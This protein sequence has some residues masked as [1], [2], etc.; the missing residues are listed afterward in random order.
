MDSVRRR[1]TASLPALGVLALAA[2]HGLS[3]A[4]TPAATEAAAPPL[5]AVG[6]AL[7]LPE[8]RLFDGSVLVPSQAQGKITLIYWWASTCPFC[9]LQS[10]EMQKLW[11][12]H[13][14]RGLQMLALSVDRKPQEAEAYLQKKGYSF[15]AGWVTPEIQRVLPNPRGL[16]VTLVRGRDGKVLQAERG[17]M[18]AEDVELLSRWL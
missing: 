13:Q 2:R 1:I 18:F 12:A 16:P 14:G 3:L 8:V 4:Q 17:Q 5:P 11:L 10:P 7:P 6:S 9:A 15:P